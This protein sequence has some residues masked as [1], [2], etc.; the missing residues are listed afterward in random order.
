MSIAFIVDIVR[1][2]APALGMLLISVVVLACGANSPG[3]SSGASTA[4]GSNAA[5]TAAS[6]QLAVPANKVPLVIYAANGNAKAMVDAF[7]KQ[8]GIP[9][10]LYED[11]T[12][13]LLAK[14]QA[15]K[16]NPQWGMLWADGD[17]AFAGLDQQGFL[18]RGFVPQASYTDLGRSLLPKDGGWV[19]LSITLMPALIYDSTKVPNPP[20]SY[21]DL[22][23]REFKGAVGMNNPAISGPTYPFVA[24]MMN[25]LGGEQQ[26]KDYFTKLRAN[27]LHIYNTNKVT[28]GAL[29]AG[30]IKMALVQNSAAIAQSAKT[31]DLKVVFLSKA[32]VLPNVIAIQAKAPVDE[33]TEAKLFA[34][35]I[36][37]PE[38]QKVDQSGDPMG[39][40][41]F[42]PIVDGVSP[43]AS[44]PQLAPIQTQVID[45]M[46]WGA[47]QGEVTQ[48]F[49][50]N[51]A[52]Q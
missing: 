41:L 51:I 7:Q 47:R 38:G 1:R 28:L 20:A 30:D 4:S 11:S 23:M 22:L 14:I 35:F 50:D 13:P 42:Y 45:P 44:L 48:W 5:A 10:Q 9:V 34:Q 21:D 26:G 31:P 27:G 16:S 17:T 32:T 3:A 15:E 39:D 40:S 36:L 46:A 12:G 8:T 19:P 43:L 29:A 52:G 2:R 37:S 33:Q 24:G 49:S 6:T 18:L 25:Q